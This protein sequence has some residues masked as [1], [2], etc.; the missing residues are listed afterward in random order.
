MNNT[1]LRNT[2]KGT[3]LD[4]NNLRDWESF[5]KIAAILQNYFH[6][7]LLT[8]VDGPESRVWSFMVDDEI[9]ALQNDPYGNFLKSL[10]IEPTNVLIR[11]HEQW[12]LYE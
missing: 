10:S 8:K 9:I 6:A 2:K 1:I 12:E 4:F 11:I 7:T 5:D 3:I